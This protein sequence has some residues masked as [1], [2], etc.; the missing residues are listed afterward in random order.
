[1]PERTTVV[2]VVITGFAA[3]GLS[4]D[5]SLFDFLV[6]LPPMSNVVEKTRRLASAS[7]GDLPV[8]VLDP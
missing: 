2:E 5:G 7:L 3:P 1:M 8:R 4:L 6:E